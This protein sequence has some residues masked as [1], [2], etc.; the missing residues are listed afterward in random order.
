MKG[1]GRLVACAS[2]ALVFATGA[3]G[4]DDGLGAFL[5]APPDPVNATIVPWYDALD[6][7]VGARVAS[8]AAIGVD[9]ALRWRLDARAFL[10]RAEADAWDLAEHATALATQA[11]TLDQLGLIARHCENAWRS[12]Q[13]ALIDRFVRLQ[14]QSDDI[15]EELLLVRALLAPASIRHLDGATIDACRLDAVAASLELAPDHPRLVAAMAEQRLGERSSQ[16]VAM[17]APMSVWL[18][19]DVWKGTS[20]TRGGL[21]FGIDVPLPSSVGTS[22]LALSTDGLVADASLRWTHTAGSMQKGPHMPSSQPSATTFA[23]LDA[24]LT[25]LRLETQLRRLDAAR[26]WSR[27]CGDDAAPTL[28]AC[29]RRTPFDAAGFE[30]IFAAIDAELLVLHTAL[31]AIEASGQPLRRIVEGP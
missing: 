10:A 13:V 23:D 1:L 16:M 3:R 28:A 20:S 6:A 12:V 8:D 30:A 15:A 26:R 18:H 22:E 7:S 14:G 9:L 5:A 24:D 11:W 31:A 19:A 25:R 21:R 27:A 2:F 4:A 17:A 29:V